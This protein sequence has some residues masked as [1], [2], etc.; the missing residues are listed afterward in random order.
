MYKVTGTAPIDVAAHF[1][2]LGESLS[3]IGERLM[4]VEVRY[5]LKLSFIM[6]GGVKY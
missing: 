1:A 2:L 3:I 5:I 6:E 4:D